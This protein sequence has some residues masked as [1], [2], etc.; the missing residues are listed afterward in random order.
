MKLEELFTGNREGRNIFIRDEHFIPAPVT[1]SFFYEKDIRHLELKSP[2]V[3]AF[4]KLDIW[5]LEHTQANDVC[6]FVVEAVRSIERTA[7]GYSEQEEDDMTT[8]ELRKVF[9][10]STE[11]YDILL[12]DG[13]P[14]Q[15]SFRKGEHLHWTIEVEG[16]RV[17]AEITF[18]TFLMTPDRKVNTALAIV[19]AVRAMVRAAS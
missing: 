9:E 18:D 14:V 19:R 13:T 5:A 15:V 1:I 8:R 12:D 3:Q 16:Y 11:E 7:R 17:Y 2:N 10:S 4:I 6:M